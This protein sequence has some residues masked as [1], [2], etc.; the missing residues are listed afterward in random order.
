MMKME[1]VPQIGSS[2]EK[3]QN[4]F[5][6]NSD[7]QNVIEG[8]NPSKL[9]LM[10]QRGQIKRKQADEAALIN[11]SLANAELAAVPERKRP[12]KDQR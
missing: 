8:S 9:K 3:A 2:K 4:H 5:R 7:I 12:A 6:M 1:H 10:Q 11:Q